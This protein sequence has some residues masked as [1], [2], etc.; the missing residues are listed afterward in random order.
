MVNLLVVEGIWVLCLFGFFFIYLYHSPAS[1]LFSILQL[2]DLCVQEYPSVISTER[3][4]VDAA[5]YKYQEANTA[6]DLFD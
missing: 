1:I 4:V 2:L 5:H 3:K 6:A